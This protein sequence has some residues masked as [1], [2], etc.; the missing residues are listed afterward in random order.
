SDR[1]ILALRVEIVPLEVIVRNVAAGTFC[2][3][4]GKQQKLR[5]SQRKNL[6]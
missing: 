2:K 6:V 4:Y 3:R 5:F 1:E